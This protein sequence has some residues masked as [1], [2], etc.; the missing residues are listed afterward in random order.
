MLLSYLQIVKQI[1]F[2][3]EAQILY[4]ISYKIN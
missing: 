4:K 3:R 1:T 2:L